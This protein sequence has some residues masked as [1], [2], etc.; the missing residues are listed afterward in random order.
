MAGIL[1]GSSAGLFIPGKFIGLRE[2]AGSKPKHRKMRFP[3][4]L[5]WVAALF[6]VTL[7]TR[8]DM[9]SR[10]SERTRPA[11]HS[12]FRGRE[13]GETFRENHVRDAGRGG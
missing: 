3:F 8:H 12:L 10:L 13:S 9:I 11:V 2:M 7:L 6:T 5:G 4:F 1:A